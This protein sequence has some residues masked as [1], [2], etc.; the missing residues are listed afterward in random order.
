MAVLAEREGPDGLA[1]PDHFARF[2]NGRGLLSHLLA[3][4][5]FE[6][7][8]QREGSPLVA[9]SALLD[10]VPPQEAEKAAA[11]E[12]QQLELDSGGRG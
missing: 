4:E 5:D 10:T 7:L 12:R 3:A 11:W 8:G 9:P 2:E 6:F 1:A